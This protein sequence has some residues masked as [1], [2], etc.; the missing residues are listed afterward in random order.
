M[1]EPH[2]QQEEDAVSIKAMNWVWEH[3][4]SRRGARLVLLAIAD[5][6][7][8]AGEA[9]PSY[10]TLQRKTRF[11]RAA[12]AEGIEK[13]VQLGELEIDESR[14]GKRGQN[15]YRMPMRTVTGSETELVRKAN[16]SGNRTGSS[17]ETEPDLV[18]K[19]NPIT[20][21]NPPAN[22]QRVV[23]LPQ[24]QPEAIRSDGLHPLPDDFSLSDSM[25]RWA[26]QTF[27]PALDVDHETKQFISHFRAEGVRKRSWPDAWQKW[28]RNSAK[29]ASER[30]QRPHLRAVGQTPEERGIF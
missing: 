11:G 6:A 4:Q 3:S 24:Q 2:L 12:I 14:K 17:S 28:M 27:G 13:L 22:R 16:Q 1:P 18:R 29:Y 23:E 7:N 21:T 5:N 19:P 9:W 10:T 25:R 15:F 20:T 8:D 26:L 30:Q